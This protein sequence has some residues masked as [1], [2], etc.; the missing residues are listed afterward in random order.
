VNPATP[1]EVGDVSVLYGANRVL[2][3]VA[4]SAAGNEFIALLDASGCGKTTLLRT[5]CG[6]VPLAGDIRM[7]HPKFLQK[8]IGAPSPTVGI[9][10]PPITA[11]DAVDAGKAHAA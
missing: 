3:H 10:H 2:D 1:L 5:I 9:P 6:F 4:L 11:P 8:G 7:Q